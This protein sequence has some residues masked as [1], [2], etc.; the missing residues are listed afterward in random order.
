MEQEIHIDTLA[1]AI[2]ASMEGFKLDGLSLP[3]DARLLADVLGDMIY[4]RQTSIESDQLPENIQ[5]L[6]VKYTREASHERYINF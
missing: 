1:M 6:I 2:S 3:S 5:A 4:R